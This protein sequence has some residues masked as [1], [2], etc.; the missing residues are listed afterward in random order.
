MTLIKKSYLRMSLLS[1]SVDE[2][3]EQLKDIPGSAIVEV[4]PD[5]D[6]RDCIAGYFVE[7]HG[8]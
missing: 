1:F 4:T 2:L 8:E 5:V 7:I 6:S 3:R